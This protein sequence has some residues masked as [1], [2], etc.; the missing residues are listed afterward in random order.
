MDDEVNLLILLGMPL[1]PDLDVGFDCRPFFGLH[2]ALK[3]VVELDGVE[4][5]DL[6]CRRLGGRFGFL[7]GVEG[8][9]VFPKEMCVGG[10][11]RSKLGDDE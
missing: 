4:G 8:T 10:I 3:K 5:R 9:G 6:L 1:R 7:T 11:A 2:E